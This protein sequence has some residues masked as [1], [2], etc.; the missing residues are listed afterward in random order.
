MTDLLSHEVRGSGP[1]LVLIH[2]TGSTGL[3]SWGTVIDQLASD[4]T[5]VL[6]NLPGSGNSPLPDAPLDINTI[7][8]QIAATARAAGLEEFIVAGASLGAPVAIK[9]AVRHPRRVRGLATVV[10]Y[11]HLRTTLRL[12]LELWAAMHER[13]DEDLGKFLA[14]ISF[15][16]EYLATLPPEVVQQVCERFGGPPTPGR[17]AQ[18]ALT[19]GIDVRADLKDIRVPT[20]VVAATGDRFVA[21][22]HS[23]ELAAG[24]PGAQL[25]QVPG[26]HASI[27]E[28]PE[29][30]RGALLDFL[31]GL[32][33]AS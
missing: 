13:G 19:L 27:M 15:S 5:V 29:R 17:T 21:P 30:T 11:A 10:G 16:E 25:V 3:G 2:G 6:P 24:I 7:A 8:D 28:D 33:P 26:G 20:L 12:N 14:S 4:H 1:G 9:V 22:E 18:L 23:V 32:A 31:R